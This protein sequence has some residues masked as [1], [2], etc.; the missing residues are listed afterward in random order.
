AM[1]WCPR[2]GTGIS[3]HEISSEERPEVTHTSP[4][5]RFPLRGRQN[6]YLL[7]WT[8]TPWTLTSNVACAVHPDLIYVKVR[9]GEDIYYLIKERLEAVTSSQGPV[10]ALEE[11]TGGQMVGWTY[12][13][14]FDE[15][16]AQQGV[17]HRVIPWKEVSTA[18]GT[19]I[20]HIAPGC[21]KED[22]ELGKQFDLKTIA[23]IDESGI[24]IEG[25]GPFTGQQAA[26]VAKPIIRSLKEKNLLYRTE[27]Y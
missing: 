27:E 3:Q 23:P 12:D 4:T 6:E 2:C 7:V 21:G 10:E 18:E 5:V 15:L 8:T 13:G 22:F 26:A 25:F 19:G 16:A 11:L 20:V 14:P 17:E 1:P 9:Q 24:F